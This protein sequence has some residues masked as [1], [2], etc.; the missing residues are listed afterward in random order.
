[1]TRVFIDGSAGTAGLRIQERLEGRDDLNVSTLPE[2]LRK[3]REARRDAL[4]SCDAAILCLPD[5]ASAESVS[6]IENPAVRVIDTST[7]HRV[8]P[9]WAYGFPELSPLFRDKIASGSRVASAGCHA[10]GF[11]SLVYPLVE[12]GL[13]PR[14]ALL[15]CHS[16]TGYS[17]GG[18]AMIAEYEGERHNVLLDSPR[19]YALGQ[20]HKHLCEMRTVCG[21]DSDPIFCPI[22]ADYY[23]GMCVT[24]PLFASQLKAGAGIEDVRTLLREKYRGPVVSY[25]DALD[26]DGFVAANQLAGSDLMQVGVYGNRE[27]MTLV[28]RFDNL[29]KGAS[30]CAVE[31]L[32][33]MLGLDETTGLVL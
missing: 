2:G 1:M 26:I 10:G 25:S 21:L 4:N 3:D 29:G 30:G 19:Q 11:I 5:A 20:R 22:A 24:V 7:A 32:N 31:C 8:A 14:D 15:T 28:S 12:S 18:R 13:L 27:R 23:C 33:I 16:V 6:L 17:G 9:G